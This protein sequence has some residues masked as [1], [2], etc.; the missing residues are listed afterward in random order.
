M[1]ELIPVSR[2][3]FGP[4]EAAAVQAVLASHWVGMGPRT[5]EFE[6]ALAERLGVR[7]VLATSSCTAA[8]HLALTA[9]E[10][11]DRKEIIVPSLTF[12]ATVQAIVM[13][14][15]TPVFAEVNPQTLTI[16]CE[17]VARLLNHNTRAILPVHFAGLPCDLEQ[18]RRLADPAG[19]EIIS[20]GAHAFGSTVR[21]VPIGRQGTATCF[22]FSANKN[23]SCGEGGAVATPSDALAA[24]LKKL[25]FLGI[26]H[27]TWERRTR[28]RPWHYTVDGPGFRYH[29]SDIN[30]AIGLA[31]LERLDDFA[32]MRRR[33]AATY[34][35]G[36][37]GLPWTLPVKRDLK[38]TIPHL[39]VLRV[40]H[41]LRDALYARLCAEG[42]SCGV[43]YVPNHQQPAFR[44]FTRPLSVTE[45]L[46]DQV[47]SLPLHTRL[48]AGQIEHVIT[49]VSHF[50][51]SA[52]PPI[53]R[54]K[55]RE[56]KGAIP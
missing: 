38:H 31:Q 7:H 12:A 11:D 39:Y 1:P 49:K 33:I 23:I 34:D 48:D 21:G 51:R 3:D 13:A 52:R 9:L 43:H 50:L 55:M 5:A 22:S 24:R 45:K 25:R 54:R 6:V 36:L 30:A 40:T 41:G 46:A 2:P 14:G 32:R 29:M 28:A 18:L 4:A 15:Y 27:H 10:P 53:R 19:V 37:A 16:D 42:I 20:D 26:S 35:D 47:I 8:I 44:E 17:D 56:L